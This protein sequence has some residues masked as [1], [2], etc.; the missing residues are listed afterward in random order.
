M[1]ARISSRTLERRLAASGG[2]PNEFKAAAALG[3]RSGTTR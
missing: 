2:I 1:M 3:P